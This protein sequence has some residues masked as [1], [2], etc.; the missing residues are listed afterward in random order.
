MRVFEMT[1]LLLIRHGESVLG[2]QKRYAGHTDTPLTDAGRSQILRLR[3]Q[4]K[5]SNVDRI[6]SS[7]LIRCRQ[8]AAILAPDQEIACSEQLRELNFG[9]WEGRTAEECAALD[10]AHFRRWMEDPVS[11]SPPS[12]ESLEHLSERVNDF[13][14]EL[15]RRFPEQTIALVMHGGPIRTLLVTDIANFWSVSVPLGAFIECPERRCIGID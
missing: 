5:Q 12:G 8:T 7:D 4:F 3:G 9:T 2:S 1:R 11:V 15:S 10:P 14:E 6:Y 13:V